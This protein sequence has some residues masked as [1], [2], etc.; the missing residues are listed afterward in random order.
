MS[1]KQRLY[2]TDAQAAV[3]G[4]HAA[5]ARFL[6][7]LGLE[8]RKMWTP[9]KRHHP[10]RINFAT[11]S[12][13]LTELR[14]DLDWLRD[15]STVI[16]Q[17]ALRDLDRAFTNFFAGH[18]R[19]P[20]FKSARDPKSGF[21]IRDLALR[22]I[23]RKWAEI[24][25]PKTGWVKFR[26]S[27]PYQDALKASSA[28]ANCH[29]GRW[30]V[31]LTTPPRPRVPAGTGAMVGIDV[32]VANSVATSDGA[33]HHA[34][35]L[36]AGGQKR[37][38][39]LQRTL[40]RQ[41]KGSNRRALTLSRLAGLRR[42]L[43]NR[44]TDWVE[45]LTTTFARAYDLA[46]VEDLKIANMTRR[47]A[48]RP[49]PETPGN[50]LPNNARAKAGLNKAILASCWGQFTTR[51]GHK[52]DVSRVNPYNTSRQCQSCKHIDAGNRESQAVFTCVE[53]GYQ[54]HADTNA[55]QNILDRA[56]ITNPGTP[57]DRTCKPRQRATSTNPR[58]P[59]NAGV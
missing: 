26:L 23:N 22:R 39:G 7:N 35:S 47:P 49:D 32:G 15:G 12:R 41:E 18:A 30:H 59:A 48:P 25:I 58:T 54:A 46:A 2:P 10:E 24:L 8:Q 29:N 56:L 13:Q 4:M 31:S 44:R 3:L 40:A 45:Q 9:A 20:R 17:G 16:Q 38:L 36:S 53:C 34:P 1:L 5:H 14:K 19:Y 11:Q 55:A 21:V 28:R 43:E 27:Y 42:N 52:M 50:F 37:F 33:F 6:F 57:G 51:L